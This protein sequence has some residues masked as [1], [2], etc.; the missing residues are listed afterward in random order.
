MTGVEALLEQVNHQ[1]AD[2]V[3][4]RNLLALL[5]K[6]SAAPLQDLLNHQE[7]LMQILY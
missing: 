5:Q 3:N 6:L 4:A 1:L 7:Q 2:A